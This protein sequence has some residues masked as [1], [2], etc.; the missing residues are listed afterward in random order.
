MMPIMLE[1][2]EEKLNE[3]CRSGDRA[4]A[5]QQV[6]LGYGPQ[7]R[8]YL[9][10]TLSSPEEGDDVFQ[11]VSVA[12]WEG[13]PAFRFQC[14]L[15][16]WCYAIAHN[17]VSKR[18]TRYSRRHGMRLDTGKQEA[19]PA[20]S[21]TSLLEHQERIAI[22]AVAIAQLS[23]KEREVL[24]L[25]SERGLSFDEIGLIFGLSE[26]NARKRYQRAKDRLKSL[27]GASAPG[28]TAS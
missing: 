1:G 20:A 21:L 5:V 28:D 4:E 25:R 27:I 16:T 9:R 3:L 17:L 13:L 23:P 26:A 14:S 19:L 8:G 24:I 12:I 7:L 18:L 10:G 15:R 2:I 22:A 6:L 11:E